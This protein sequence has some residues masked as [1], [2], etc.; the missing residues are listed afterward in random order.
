MEAHRTGKSPA[1]V[2]VTSCWGRHADQLRDSLCSPDV[3]RRGPAGARRGCRLSGQA[4]RKG[5]TDGRKGGT[6]GREGPARA[7]LQRRTLPAKGR[8]AGR[9]WS[10]QGEKVEGGA[11]SGMRECDSTPADAVPGDDKGSGLAL[12]S[13][14][15]RTGEGRRS[16]AVRKGVGGSEAPGITG[17]RGCKVVK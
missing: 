8:V 13:E 2:K 10:F 1:R 7:Q 5:G 12:T 17:G 11:Q 9:P 3:R 14:V 6:D 4:S 16:R 15:G